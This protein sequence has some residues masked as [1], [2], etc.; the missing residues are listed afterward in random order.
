MS[1]LLDTNIVVWMLLDPSR[2]PPVVRRI[3]AEV[4]RDRLSISALA[5]YEISIKSMRGRLALVPDLV[6]AELVRLGLRMLAFTARHGVEAGRLPPLHKDPFDRGMIAQAQV[7]GLSLVT[8]DR[9]LA[10]YPVS[11]L[12]V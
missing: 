9:L 8:A 10:R 3:F 11:T 4:P 5:L 7:E 12:V 6:E 1:F 2:L